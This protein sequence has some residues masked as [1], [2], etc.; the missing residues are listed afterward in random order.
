MLTG[1]FMIMFAAA[2]MVLYC[3]SDKTR[4]PLSARLMNRRTRM[5][6]ILHDFFSTT[7]LFLGGIGVIRILALLLNIQKDYGEIGYIVLSFL[8]IIFPMAGRKYLTDHGYFPS[9]MSQ[10]MRGSRTGRNFVYEIFLN[11]TVSFA[12]QRFFPCLLGQAA[13]L[14]N[15]P[16]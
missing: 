5:H 11:V 8:L 1:I 9:R 4:T 2:V 10:Y 7:I 12:C 15:N 14:I 16:F 3:R 6:Y 13:V